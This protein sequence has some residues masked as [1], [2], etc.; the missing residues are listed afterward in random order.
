VF[1]GGVRYE[2]EKTDGLFNFL[3]K[4]WTKGTEAHRVVVLAAFPV[5]TPLGFKAVF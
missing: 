1:P 3:A 4:A 5:R 2:S